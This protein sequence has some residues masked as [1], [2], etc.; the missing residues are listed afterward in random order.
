MNNIDRVALNERSWCKNKLSKESWASGRSYIRTVVWANVFVV[1]ELL[2]VVLDW[3]GSP[4]SALTPW[5]GGGDDQ[6]RIM[7]NGS[8]S[9]AKDGR[10]DGLNCVCVG[11][12]LRFFGYAAG[13][14][15]YRGQLYLTLRRV[16]LLEY[17]NECEVVVT[18]AERRLWSS[19]LHR[20]CGC[21][22]FG[23]IAEFCNVGSTK[24]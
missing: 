15:C 10:T 18:R 22:H 17:S 4:N 6:R 20:S 16:Y 24:L 23:G 9:T 12:P 3:F 7:Q 5:S 19:E 1:C 13:S 21:L 8:Y 11:R 2:H 14:V